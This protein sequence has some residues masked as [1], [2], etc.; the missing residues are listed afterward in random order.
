[1]ATHTYVVK[2]LGIASMTRW[3]FVAG[4]LVACLPMSLCSLFFFTVIASLTQI[5]EGWQN[6][7]V[8]F[9]GQ[10]IPLNIVDLL[11]LQQF[12]TVL[13]ALDALG[14]LG[15]LLLGLVLI[16]LAGLMVAV[17]FVLLGLLY[18]FTGRMEL[19]LVEK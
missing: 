14:L 10:K 11:Q 2:R 6:L 13:R 16:A 7:G 3:G 17:S 1:M 8:S 9:L 4:A 12:L 19:T 15:V 5:V 18:N